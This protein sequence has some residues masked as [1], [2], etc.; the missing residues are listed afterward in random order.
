MQAVAELLAVGI[1]GEENPALDATGDG[2]AQGIPRHPD[3][4]RAA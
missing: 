4:A 3:A 1:I 2:V